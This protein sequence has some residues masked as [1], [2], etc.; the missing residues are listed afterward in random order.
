MKPEKHR[1][2]KK[3]KKPEGILEPNCLLALFKHS[4]EDS[5]RQKKEP[6]K[7]KTQK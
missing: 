6:V 5:S 3:K 4:R 2:L 1:S 7:L